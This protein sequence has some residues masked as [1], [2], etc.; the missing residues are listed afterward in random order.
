ME[1]D[2]FHKDGRLKDGSNVI[3]IQ[4][5]VRQG[6]ILSPLLFN[7]Y[8]EQIFKEALEEL[9][10]GILVNGERLNN[11]RYA[12]DTVAFADSPEALQKIMDRVVATSMKYGTKC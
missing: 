2:C 6:C 12:D 11:L 9:D 4:C 7:L 5:G 8:S 3:E 1:S 10:A